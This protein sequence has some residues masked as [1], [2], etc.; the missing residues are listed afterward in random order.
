[1]QSCNRPEVIRGIT[2]YDE[3]VHVSTGRYPALGND[4][5]VIEIAHNEKLAHLGDRWPVFTRIISAE[6]FEQRML[7]YSNDPHLFKEEHLRNL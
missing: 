3:T 2:E 7:D 4:V 5:E 1:M 6:L